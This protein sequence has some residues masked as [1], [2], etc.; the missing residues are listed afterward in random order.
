[1]FQ[2]DAY[3]STFWFVDMEYDLPTSKGMSLAYWEIARNL[4]LP[5]DNLSATIQYNDG[6]AFFGSLG[7]VWLAGLN[8]YL[9]LG[10][11]G[12][13]IDVLYRVSSGANSPDFQ[14][15]TSWMVP[16]LHDR[17]EFS[18]FLDIW[19]QDSGPDTKD[20]V[21]L[22]EP[23]LWYAVSDHVALGTEVEISKNFIF[24]ETGIQALP[25]VGFRW[26]F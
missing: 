2:P 14:I 1:M 11:I 10:G 24:G 8:Y 13:P 25:T 23:Q 19:S 12:L 5:V 3:G 15:T 17:L 4:S 26:I 18:G 7:Q 9:D 22:A 6:T 20:I 16:F 21:V